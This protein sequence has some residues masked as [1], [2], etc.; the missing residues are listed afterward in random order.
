MMKLTPEKYFR[1]LRTYTLKRPSDVLRFN[2]LVS[3]FHAYGQ[4]PTREAIAISVD[5]ITTLSDDEYRSLG[6]TLH[7]T[8]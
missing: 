4:C 8:I 3:T 2:K 7:R 5:A 6:R 1:L